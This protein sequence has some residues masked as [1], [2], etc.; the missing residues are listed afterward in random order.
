MSPALLMVIVV[1]AAG[2]CCLVA[3]FEAIA[4][5]SPSERRE[6]EEKRAQA[7]KEELLRKA[8]QEVTDR[9]RVRAGTTNF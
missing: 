9:P 3:A 6:Y 4:K 5:G 8:N 1:I 7:D 2:V